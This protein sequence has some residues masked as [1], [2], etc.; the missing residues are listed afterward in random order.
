[1]RKLVYINVGM[2]VFSFRHAI[3]NMKLDDIKIIT[4]IIG[5]KKRGLNNLYF[6]QFGK[7]IQRFVLSYLSLKQHTLFEISSLC[8]V[9]K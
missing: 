9:G 5:Y 1:M 4:K 8:N 6:D 7:Y 3:Y 2:K